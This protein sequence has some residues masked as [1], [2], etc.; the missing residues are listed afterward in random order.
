MYPYIMRLTITLLIFCGFLS[1][2][3]QQVLSSDEIERVFGGQKKV[4]A[5]GFNQWVQDQELT[6][7]LSLVPLEYKRVLL[8]RYEEILSVSEMIDSSTYV[9]EFRKILKFNSI[10]STQNPVIS[11][12]LFIDGENT[13][14]NVIFD[15]VIDTTQLIDNNPSLEFEEVT[16]DIPDFLDDQFRQ[17]V[18]LEFMK[19]TKINGVWT[20]NRILQ[21]LSH[22]LDVNIEQISIGTSLFYMLNNK[23]QEEKFVSTITWGA[24]TYANGLTAADHDSGIN[25][26]YD[27]TNPTNNVVNSWSN[28][29]KVS[30]TADFNKYQ[31]LGLSNNESW[32]FARMDEGIPINVIL[33]VTGSDT[34][35]NVSN[36]KTEAKNLETEI[37]D[38]LVSRLRKSLFQNN[39][40]IVH[41]R[42]DKQRIVI[43]FPN[44]RVTKKYWESIQISLDFRELL[45]LCPCGSF[46][47]KTTSLEY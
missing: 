32:S 31:Q 15:R 1:A 12:W 33:G 2:Q 18:L 30:S 11:S 26:P 41:E 6:L 24:G 38:S 7:D 10:I 42:P 28:W 25:L 9:V 36:D 20:Q 14:Y 47:E 27:F 29:T 34:E 22:L 45:G 13:N 3:S 23:K 44:G 19:N 39:T 21:K 43:Q 4:E 35:N 37:Y 8:N 17:E 16:S 40:Q 46:Q 5:F